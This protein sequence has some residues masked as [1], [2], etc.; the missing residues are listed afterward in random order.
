MTTCSLRDGLNV[1]VTHGDAVEKKIKLK[2][3][4][5]MLFAQLAWGSFAQNMDWDGVMTF[6]SAEER[7]Q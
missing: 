1:N 4:S 7:N 3:I 6:E 2:S 5:H